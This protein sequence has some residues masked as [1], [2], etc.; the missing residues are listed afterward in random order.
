MKDEQIIGLYNQLSAEH[1][2]THEKALVT[3]CKA[4]ALEAYELGLDEMHRKVEYAITGAQEEERWRGPHTLVDQLMTS[5]VVEYSE[6]IIEEEN[7]TQQG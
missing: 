7:E 6:E 3:T 1:H 4:I 2:M 5:K